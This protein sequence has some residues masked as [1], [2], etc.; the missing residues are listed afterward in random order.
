MRCQEAGQCSHQKRGKEAVVVLLKTNHPVHGKVSI[1]REYTRNLCQCFAV[2]GDAGQV[3]PQ[4]KDD[5]SRMGS[6]PSLNV[7]SASARTA[8][9]GC[10]LKGGG[11]PWRTPLPPTISLV[12][13]RGKSLGRP[14]KAVSIVAQAASDALCPR[15]CLERHTLSLNTL[16]RSEGK[17]TVV[18]APRRPRA[19]KTDGPLAGGQQDVF[20]LKNQNQ[21]PIAAV[22]ESAQS[23]A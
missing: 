14:Q 1:Y 16:R 21:P 10:W 6:R 22:W 2:L 3:L 7:N 8:P 13:R 9:R 17:Y 15:Q 11:K 18:K 12:Q 23:E 5:G 20:E 19:K 4:K